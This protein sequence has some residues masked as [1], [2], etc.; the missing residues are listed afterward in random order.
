MVYAFPT[1]VSLLSLG[2]TSSVDLH[3]QSPS[4]HRDLNSS[5]ETYM[6]DVLLYFNNILA[7]LDILS[8]LLI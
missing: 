2:G 4:K 3:R 5:P 7:R 8:V 1:E 6:S